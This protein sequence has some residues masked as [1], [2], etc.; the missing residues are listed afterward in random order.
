M[1]DIKSS[2]IDKLTILQYN[3]MSFRD[4]KSFCIHLIEDLSLRLNGRNISGRFSKNSDEEELC[5]EIALI[6]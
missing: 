4:V 3:A 5:S 6:L 1:I 2:L